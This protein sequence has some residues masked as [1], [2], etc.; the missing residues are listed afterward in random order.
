MRGRDVPVLIHD[1]LYE[2]IR[3]SELQV[4][5][6]LDSLVTI[7]EL[8]DHLE[9]VLAF[10]EEDLAAGNSGVFLEIALERKHKK[11]AKGLIAYR[12][13]QSRKTGALWIFL[14]SV[15]AGL[16]FYFNIFVLSLKVRHHFF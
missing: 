13:E 11:A 4:Y 7:P 10:H 8:K 5:K 12:A 3:G 16:K 1:R 14:E 15:K 6:F 9:S 2:E